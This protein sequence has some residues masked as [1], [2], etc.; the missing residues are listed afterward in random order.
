MLATICVPLRTLRWVMDRFP[1][2]NLPS[3]SSCPFCLERRRLSKH[4]IEPLRE[5]VY[6]TFYMLA[7]KEASCGRAGYRTSN[8]HIAIT[9]LPVG[10]M[11]KLQPAWI[12]ERSIPLLAAPTG[13]QC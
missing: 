8:W 13:Q 2:L 3:K 11:S 5:P 1:S 4:C 10:K 12:S 9:S 7:V 6:T